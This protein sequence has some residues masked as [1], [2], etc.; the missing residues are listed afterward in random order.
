MNP[1]SEE[2]H[3]ILFNDELENSP[4]Q[5]YLN[6]LENILHLD[7][8][9]SELLEIE[10][11]RNQ[12]LDFDFNEIGSEA[13]ENQQFVNQFINDQNQTTMDHN[14]PCLQISNYSQDV[15][16]SYKSTNDLNYDLAHLQALPLLEP[17]NNET[18]YDQQG[19]SMYQRHGMQEATATS[20]ITNFVGENQQSMH[21]SEAMTSRNYT[22]DQPSHGIEHEFILNQPSQAPYQ[23]DGFNQQGYVQ[24]YT[25]DNQPHY[26]GMVSST[27]VSS[28]YSPANN[29]H[30]PAFQQRGLP[31]NSQQCSS[32]QSYTRYPP[33]IPP[34]S[35]SMIANQN[36]HGL[37][38]RPVRQSPQPINTIQVNNCG[39]FCSRLQQNKIYV[40]SFCPRVSNL[41]NFSK[42][43]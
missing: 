40:C 43:F 4:N 9:E 28:Q 18:N 26:S 8:P 7:I 24:N 21:S 11:F 42:T 1:M 41:I 29:S 36:Q 3:G 22:F 33:P 35:S 31:S 20:S 19:S 15:E 10:E 25:N 37:L 32:S 27:Q 5:D 6:E 16:N 23:C 2:L 34:T 13:V 30:Y 39:E 38:A 17:S 14:N 12:Q